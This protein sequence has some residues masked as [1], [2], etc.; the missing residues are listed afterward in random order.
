MLP[1]A[2]HARS[3]FPLSFAIRISFSMSSTYLFFAST[4]ATFFLTNDDNDTRPGGVSLDTWVSGFQ[5]RFIHLGSALTD[6]VWARFGFLFDEAGPLHLHRS[7]SEFLQFVVLVL[8]LHG[9]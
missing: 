4:S 8:H 9:T 2:A 5:W 7:E 3:L 6:W 1:S